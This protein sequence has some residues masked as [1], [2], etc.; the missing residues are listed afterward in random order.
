MFMPIWVLMVIKNVAVAENSILLDQ[1]KEKSS[2]ILNNQK[3]NEIQNEN[4]KK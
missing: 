3:V 1:N 2:V 4:K